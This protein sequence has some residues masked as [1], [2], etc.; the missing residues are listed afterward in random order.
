MRGF[1]TTPIT[2]PIAYYPLPYRKLNK[3][4]DLNINLRLTFFLKK[5]DKRVK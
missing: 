2:L 3:M 5:F 4:I 1:Q